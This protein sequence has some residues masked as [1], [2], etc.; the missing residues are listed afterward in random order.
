MTFRA[1]EVRIME[2]IKAHPDSVTAEIREGV[3]DRGWE[4][5]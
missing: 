1:Q 3:G 2:Y 5:D 4:T